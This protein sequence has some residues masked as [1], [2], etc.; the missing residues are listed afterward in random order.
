MAIATIV[1]G[2]VVG[3]LTALAGVLAALARFEPFD[4]LDRG[5][6]FS[7]HDE[8]DHPVPYRADAAGRRSPPGPHTIP[9]AKP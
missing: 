4:Y 6:A 7:D 5:P 9:V 3:L 8:T 1:F 2:I